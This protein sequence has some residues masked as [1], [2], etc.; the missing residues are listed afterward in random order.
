MSA[1]LHHN[2]FSLQFKFLKK[3]AVKK[4]GKQGKEA[5]PSDSI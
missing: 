4:K 3:T 1:Y 2:A 5:F